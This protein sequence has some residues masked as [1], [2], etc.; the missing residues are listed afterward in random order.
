MREYTLG[1]TKEEIAVGS[2]Q[3]R[4]DEPNNS[5]VHRSQ[6]PRCLRL[7]LSSPSRMLRSW[8]RIPHEAW[9]SVCV[10]VDLYVGKGFASG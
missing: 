8:I 9:L 1:L 2:T 3:L 5:T 7:E 4:N 6:W 10:C